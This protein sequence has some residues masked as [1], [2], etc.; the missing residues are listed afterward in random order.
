VKFVL[1]IKYLKKVRYEKM[2]SVLCLK[3]GFVLIPTYFERVCFI[4][5]NLA[6]VRVFPETY[7]RYP[8]FL[9]SRLQL[10]MNNF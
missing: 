1:N 4:N 7:H 10:R 3:F 8:R 9:L 5:I 6:K 2:T